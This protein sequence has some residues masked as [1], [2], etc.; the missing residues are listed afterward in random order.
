MFTPRGAIVT[1]STS[2]IG[3][4]IAQA[5]ARAGHPVLLNGFGDGQ[6]IETLHCGLAA[7]TGVKVAYSAADI[8]TPAEI[9]QL[10]TQAH[11]S[12]MSGYTTSAFLRAK[13]GKSLRQNDVA[14]H[15]SETTV[16]ANAQL[17]GQAPA[18]P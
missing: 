8:S 9:S 5:L 6:A 3:L 4:A 13:L 17:Q 1:G 2:D 15:I 11:Y 10:V 12:T 7:E 16:A 14:L 18:A